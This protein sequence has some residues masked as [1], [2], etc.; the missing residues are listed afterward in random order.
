[1]SNKKWRRAAGDDA[2][3]PPPVDPSPAPAHPAPQP[4][5]EAFYRPDLGKCVVAPA[6]GPLTDEQREA[7]RSD[8]MR[9]CW[10]VATMV[11]SVLDTVRLGD[12]RRIAAGDLPVPA[13]V[14]DESGKVT[15]KL[16]EPPKPEESPHT[17][18]RKRPR[19]RLHPIMILMKIGVQAVSLYRRLDGFRPEVTAEFTRML[20]VNKVCNSMVD[21]IAKGLT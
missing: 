16:T 9:L 1:M 8:C 11:S 15:D 5:P 4:S 10:Q 6:G 17:D 20:Q 12:L 7:M 2:P 14:I 3:P 13:G 18:H 21:R 19:G